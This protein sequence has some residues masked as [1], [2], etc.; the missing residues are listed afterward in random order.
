MGMQRAGDIARLAALARPVIGV[1][2]N[3]GV[4]HIE[5]FN[6]REELARAKGELVAALPAEGL[7]V[8]NADNEFF[9][10][11]AQ[12]NSARIASFGQERGDY[13]VD[14]Y[15]AL[16]GGGSQFSGGGVALRRSIRGRHKSLNAA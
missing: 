5:F 8:L 7:A 4:V 1:V 3:V 9:P 16:S 6:S 2:T 11:L 12:M 10:L 14:Q 13:R 15:E